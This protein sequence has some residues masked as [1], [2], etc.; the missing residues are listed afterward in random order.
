MKIAVYAISKNEE[1]HV[2]RFCETAKDA[3]LIIIAD[4]GSEDRTVEIA[5]ECGAIVHEITISPWRFDRARDAA[6]ALV[7]KDVDVCVSLDLD[8]LLEPGWRKTV[9][10]I[11]EKGCT[12]V[13][14]GFDPGNGMLF[15]PTRIHARHG[16]HW[17]YPCHEYITPDPRSEDKVGLI[18]AVV[19]RHAPDPTKSRGQ[20]LDILAM[21]VKEDPHCH[22][23]A[24]YYG[25]ELSFAGQWDKSAEQLKRYLDMPG[26]QW[27]LERSHAMRMI[28]T[29]LEQAGRDGMK[30]FRLACAEEPG[31][32]ENWYELSFACYRKALWSESYGAAK[33]ALTITQKNAQHTANPN[34]WNFYVHDY[35]AIAAYRLG[36]ME[37]AREHGKIALEMSPNDKRLQEN[38]KYYEG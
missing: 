35:L 7:P 5:R 4:T 30:W 6:L 10:E 32:R 27:P 33:T 19:M 22:R 23:S 16:Y 34:A 3:D 20:Y 12:R 31:V 26:A 13:S 1:K 38:M 14:C 15:Y 36:L 9:E 2:K 24:Y 28:G 17:K 21:A 37:E 25:R 29:A 8:E 11:F 18:N